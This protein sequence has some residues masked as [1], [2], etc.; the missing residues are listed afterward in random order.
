M[1]EM[2]EGDQKIG[3]SGGKINEPQ[4]GNTQQGE[5]SQNI[6]IFTINIVICVVPDG[7]QNYH[8]GYFAMHTAIR[9]LATNRVLQVNNNS[10]FFEK[11]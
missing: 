6:V 4:G 5:Y 7:K 10:I 11:E 8:R 9:P 1:S 3:N 2:G